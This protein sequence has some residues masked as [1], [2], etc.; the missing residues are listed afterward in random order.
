MKHI[1]SS[2]IPFDQNFVRWPFLTAREPGKCSQDLCS[3]EKETGFGAPLPS[4]LRAYCLSL[5]L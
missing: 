4:Y 5:C 2:D 1:T 3:R